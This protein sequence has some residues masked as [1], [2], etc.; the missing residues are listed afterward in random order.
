MI[1]GLF[2]GGQAPDEKDLYIPPTIVLNPKNENC[3][4]LKEEV[5]GP[6]LPILQYDNLDEVLRK[7]ASRPNPLALYIYSADDTEVQYILN[8]SRSGGVCVNDC[9]TH[10]LAENLPFGGIGQSGYG[11]YRGEW[12]FRT[13]THERA[14]MEF[15][16]SDF[17]QKRIPNRA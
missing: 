3:S 7:E 5:F 16:A 12:G 10:M 6:V 8:N 13:F 1:E 14:V 17:D 9:I 15:D 11:N 4:I 2:S